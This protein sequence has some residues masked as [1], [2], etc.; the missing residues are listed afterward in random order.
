MQF[1]ALANEHRPQSLIDDERLFMENPD[2]YGL[3]GAQ[4]DKVFSQYGILRSLRLKRHPE[5]PST[6]YYTKE[7]YEGAL[8]GLFKGLTSAEKNALNELRKKAEEYGS[9]LLWNTATL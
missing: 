5:R 9:S 6:T 7:Q 1:S 3:T 4:S 8:P 2:A